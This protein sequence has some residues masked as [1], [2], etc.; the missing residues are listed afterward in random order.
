MPR[1]VFNKRYQLRVGLTIK[2]WEL[3]IQNLAH[4][5][6]NLNVAVCLHTPKAIPLTGFTKPNNTGNSFA[7][8]I[9]VKPIPALFAMS[10]N[11]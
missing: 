2:P 4:L 11:W 6:G 9:D 7:R 10:I 8:I 3:A 1:S 5:F